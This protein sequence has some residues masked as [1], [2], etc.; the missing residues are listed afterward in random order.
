[1]RQFG[2]QNEAASGEEP[3]RRWSTWGGLRLFFYLE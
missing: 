1:V 2:V 3:G